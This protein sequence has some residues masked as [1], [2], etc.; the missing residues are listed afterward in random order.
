MVP[1]ARPELISTWRQERQQT[2]DEKPLYDVLEDA[3][4]QALDSEQGMPH[5]GVDASYVI[6]E[7]LRLLN[8]AGYTVTPISPS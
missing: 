8:E 4:W 2:M 7:F 5:S 6:P 1:D 3:I